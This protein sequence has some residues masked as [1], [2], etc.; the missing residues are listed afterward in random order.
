VARRT[1]EIGIRMALGARQS[2]VLWLILRETLILLALGVAIGVP[3]ALAGARLIRSQLFALSPS[4]PLTIGCATAAVLAAGALAAFLPAR[5]AV[6][7]EPMLALQS[8]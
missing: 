1:A 7:A 6:S 8:E 2:A 4:D 5:R 3:T